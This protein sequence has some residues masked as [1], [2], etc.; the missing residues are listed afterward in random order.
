[1][2]FKF[3]SIII[4]THN[5]AEILKRN[6]LAFDHQSILIK[7]EVI[8]VV[9]KCEDNTILLL[10]T[11]RKEVTYPLVYFISTAGQASVARNI[12]AK[13]AKGELLIFLDDDIIPSKN[14]LSEHVLAQESNSVVIG[15]SKPVIFPKPSLWQLNARLWWE[16]RFK[17]MNQA[18]HRFNYKD[19]FSGNFS[20]SSELFGKIGGFNESLIRSE[21]YEFGIRLINNNVKF[22]FSYQVL[23]YHHESND[24]HIW[25]K[26]VALDGGSDVVLANLYP[27][28]KNSLFIRNP[29]YELNKK[30]SS[31][32]MEIRNYIVHNYFLLIMM[33]PLIKLTLS[34]FER[35]RFR[36]WWNKSLGILYELCYWK[37]V[38]KSFN[39]NKE[40]KKWLKGAENDLPESNEM[41]IDILD[42]YKTET[43]KLYLG[44][45]KISQIK[46]LYDNL[47]IIILPQKEFSEY[48][49]IAHIKQELIKYL[50]AH[51]SP[52][53]VYFL[54]NEDLFYLYEN[55]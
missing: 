11:L 12:G 13:N 41:V 51:F 38:Q 28:L 49:S 6:L 47:E 48:I 21:D 55:M 44:N 16:D 15:Y 29:L 36:F 35:L 26:R 50:N 10:D 39:S 14:F 9:D 4:P 27:E 23:G 43:K 8:V 45:I 32:M 7:Y 37:G 3:I 31:L 2:N 1:M 25:M 34:L 20:I 30:S 54:K 33:L 19:F 52:E 5:R 53:I 46:L 22:I 17:E 42:L 18:G 24:L 40:Y